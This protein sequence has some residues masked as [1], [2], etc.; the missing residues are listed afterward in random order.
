M[1]SRF[2]IVTEELAGQRL[3]KLLHHH[4]NGEQSRTYFQ[5]LIEEKQVLLNGKPVKKRISPK[6]GDE[7]E[8]EF[9]YTPEIKLTPENIPL[10][11]LFEDDSLLVVNKPAGMV[12]HPAPGNW[13]GTFVN[14]LLYHCGDSLHDDVTMRPG[15]VH[16]LDKD[17][18]G[19]LVAAKNLRVQQQLTSLFGDREVEKEYIAVCVGNPGSGTV[20]TAIG[21]HPVHRKQMAVVESGGRSARSHLTV[22]ATDSKRS[23]VQ[24]NLETGRTHQ[25]RVHLRH[26]GAP[27]LGDA[28]YGRE[29][30]NSHYGVKRQ[31]LHAHRLGFVHPVTGEPLSFTAP[32]PEDMAD[33]IARIDRELKL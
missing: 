23:V 16:R 10:E 20:D 18:S 12:V 3:D 31:L 33:Q 26:R 4:F 7:I 27:I 6:V 2:F 8:V 21:R 11:I 15:I 14:A 29:G 24:V 17:T 9:S 5:H 22:L 25:A 13:T 32:I 1:A 19:C 28:V 30:S